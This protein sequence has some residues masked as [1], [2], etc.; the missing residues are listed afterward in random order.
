MKK[1]KLSALLGLFLISSYLIGCSSGDATSNSSSDTKGGICGISQLV[2]MSEEEQYE[3][4]DLVY[5]IEA[6]KQG[7]VEKINNCFPYT[8]YYFEVLE[9]LKGT[10]TISYA[11]FRGDTSPS[12]SIVSSLDE[13][14]IE[15]E[16]YKLY[17]RLSNDKYFTTAGFQSIIKI[18]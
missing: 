8:I 7:N 16:Q 11:Y 10:E 14:L 2:Y 17:L 13:K 1:C 15:G 5:I 4:S 18:E 12:P 6:G 3:K 9:I